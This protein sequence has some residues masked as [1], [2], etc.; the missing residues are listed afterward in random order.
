[1]ISH[2]LRH[3][4]GT[5][6]GQ[7]G[8]SA[9]P[10]SAGEYMSRPCAPPVPLVL[11]GAPRPV[12]RPDPQPPPLELQPVG[13]WPLLMRARA[14]AAVPAASIFAWAALAAF[15]SPLAV[16]LAISW[17]AAT[18]TSLA[19]WSDCSVLPCICSRW[20]R[21]RSRLSVMLAIRTAAAFSCSV[22]RAIRSSAPANFWRRQCGC[23][24]DG[25]YGQSS[26]C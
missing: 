18:S 16:A 4:L 22:A 14:F 23:R 7:G 15:L 8:S 26:Q 10:F 24:V 11:L 5:D 2:A 17:A 9:V 25:G 6:L 21:T 19:C 3:E 1:M 12:V 13:H 20:P